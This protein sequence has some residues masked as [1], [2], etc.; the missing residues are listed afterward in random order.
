[1]KHEKGKNQVLTE[2]GQVLKNWI[3]EVAGENAKLKDRLAEKEMEE[4]AINKVSEMVTVT[5]EKVSE[6]ESTLKQVQER[7]TEAEENAYEEEFNEDKECH[8][9]EENEEADD[10][11]KINEVEQE[12]AKEKW[13]TISGG[14]RRRGN[15]KSGGRGSLRGQERL[16]RR[17]N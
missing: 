14:K 16:L 5:K 12:F 10:L 15:R 6:L 8:S 3:A 1:M 2:E 4:N 9:Q 7:L 13:K 11:D 17:R